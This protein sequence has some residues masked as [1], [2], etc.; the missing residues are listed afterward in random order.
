MRRRFRKP[1]ASSSS[2]RTKRLP[3]RLTHM[4]KPSHSLSFGPTP[5]GRLTAERAALEELA[6]LFGIDGSYLDMKGERKRASPESLQ[7]IL[8]SFEV[9]ASSPR[10][11]QAALREKQRETKQ[12]EPVVV[13]WNN[14]RPRVELP[15]ARVD[16]RKTLR[17]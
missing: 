7:A 14:Q 4:L 12:F 15:A 13:A 5:G 8:R 10:K 2:S 9:D 16:A 1:S 6:G 17:G 11:V 3:P